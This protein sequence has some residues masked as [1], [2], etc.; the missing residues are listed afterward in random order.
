[1]DRS[2]HRAH[3]VSV[4]FSIALF[5]LACAAFAPHASAEESGTETD[6]ESIAWES[7]GFGVSGK[8]TGNPRG[9]SVFI[10]YAGYD[11]S[12]AAAQKWASALFVASLR[13]RGF[14]YLY[15]VQGPA[16][17]SYAGRE[18]G[19]S[20]LVAS[21]LPRVGPKT[22]SVLVVGHSSGSFVAHELLGQLASKSEIL[23]RVVYFDLDGGTSGLSGA[24]VGKLRKAYFV[25]ASDENGTVSPNDGDMRGAASTW[26]AE[27]ATY[28]SYAAK[29]SGCESGAQWC[30]HVTPITTKPHDKSGAKELDYSDYEGRA[31]A[32]GWLDDRAA[33]AGL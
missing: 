3:T 7:V 30:V 15:A 25:G 16:D 10:A 19:N 23:D 9:D 5:A 32:R 27:G 2:A 4:R 18:I 8:D 28:V 26:A 1:M 33:E 11:V 14:R 12:L 29:D 13:D 6:P 31:V 17:S 21:L 20:K 24:V 22:R